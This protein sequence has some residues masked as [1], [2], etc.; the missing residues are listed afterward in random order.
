MCW[1]FGLFQSEKYACFVV[2]IENRLKEAVRQLTDL[3]QHKVLFGAK[4]VL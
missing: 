3:V 2:T 4:F 1:I